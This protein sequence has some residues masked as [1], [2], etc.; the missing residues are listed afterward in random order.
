MIHSSKSDC[1]SQE[2]KKISISDKKYLLTD[3]QGQPIFLRTCKTADRMEENF[4]KNSIGE[5]CHGKRYFASQ[6][7]CLLHLGS[8]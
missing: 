7:P 8:W 5:T 1:F 2:N 4:Q 3:C 6:H